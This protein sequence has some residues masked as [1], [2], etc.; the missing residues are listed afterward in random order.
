MPLNGM[1]GRASKHETAPEPEM[2][3]RAWAGDTR[4]TCAVG[5]TSR[6]TARI[7]ADSRRILSCWCISAYNGLA[8]ANKTRR[9]G[10][11]KRAARGKSELLCSPYRQTLRQANAADPLRTQAGAENGQAPMPAAP[12]LAPIIATLSSCIP[13]TACSGGATAWRHRAASSHVSSSYCLQRL[14]GRARRLDL[15]AKNIATKQRREER[16]WRF[17]MAPI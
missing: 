11:N 5:G 13:H 1:A 10:S 14:A 8:R 15:A 6:C 17:C 7:A 4:G 16:A 12:P 2:T 9:S 3:W